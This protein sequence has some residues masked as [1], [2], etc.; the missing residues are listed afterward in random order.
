MKQPV[1]LCSY[2]R[3]DRIHSN[4]LGFKTIFCGHAGLCTGFRAKVFC[5]WLVEKFGKSKLSSGNGVLDVAGG[6]GA[7]AFELQVVHNIPTTV[8]DP[9]KQ[10]L[11]RAQYKVI[12]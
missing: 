8:V 3:K 5:K 4:L 12:D 2:W 1:Q 10:K 6:R 7:V 9:R 11:S